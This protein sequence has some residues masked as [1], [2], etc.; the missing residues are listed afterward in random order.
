MPFA[1]TTVQKGKISEAI[2]EKYL[3]KLN[4]KILCKNWYCRWGEIDLVAGVDGK[5][6][7]VEV[8][9]VT[10]TSYCM[11][12]ELFSKNKQRKLLRAIYRFLFLYKVKH[13]QLDLVCITQDQNKA[14]I[15][16]Y[17]NILAF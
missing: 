7:F 4:Y 15:E 10:S 12:V 13:W 1:T 11:P 14:W 5:L 2:C 3:Q 8:K 6:V 17:K 9:S 16:H